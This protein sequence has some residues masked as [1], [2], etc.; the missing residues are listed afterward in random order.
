MGKKMF[1]Y[2]IC[3]KTKVVLCTIQMQ[4]KFKIV[5]SMCL[6]IVLDTSN[7]Q[8]MFRTSYEHLINFTYI[9]NCLEGSKISIFIDIFKTSIFID[10]LFIHIFVFSLNKFAADQYE[11]IRTPP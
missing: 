1:A 3:K 5:H 11:T 7:A 8:Y 9:I 10:M 6:E 2:P 4:C